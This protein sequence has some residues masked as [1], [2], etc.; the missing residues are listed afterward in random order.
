LDPVPGW[1]GVVWNRAK[2]LEQGN[3][4]TR[5]VNSAVIQAAAALSAAGAAA[6]TTTLAW[7]AWPAAVAS[8]GT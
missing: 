7:S 6:V 4:G 8:L 5:A 1:S 3:W 2:E